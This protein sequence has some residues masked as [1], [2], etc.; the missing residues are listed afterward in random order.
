MKRYKK[1]GLTGRQLRMARRIANEHKLSAQSDFDAVRL[2]RAK[3]I[4]PFQRSNHLDWI[5]Q[6]QNQNETAT[7]NSTPTQIQLPQKL[8]ATQETLLFTDVNPI[9]R[10][11]KE[12]LQIQLE[13]TR[14]R[15]RKA[16]MLL[17]R[18]AVFV[19]LPTVI[20]VW[21]FYFVATPLYS[22]KAEFLILNAEGSA[23]SGAGGLFAGTS[24]ASSQDAVLVQNYLLTKEAM[25]QLD[26][27][28]GFKVHFS[29]SWI[30]P[31][32]RLDEE[33]SNEK[34]YKLYKRNLEIGYDPTEGVIK[35][36]SPQPIQPCP[37]NM[38]RP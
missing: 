37:S 29:Q 3:G 12:I 35:W 22:T 15:R 14:R 30:D 8:E 24:L 17:A 10:R 18:L 9:D 26:N 27:D 32:L 33:A 38:Q 20:T 19:F 11:G 28:V 2:L 16:L 6:E 31:L 5:S 23:S 36:R 13:I 4:D 21:Y 25:L 1:N 34:A 7:A